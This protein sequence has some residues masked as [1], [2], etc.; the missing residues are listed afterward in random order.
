MRCILAYLPALASRCHP[1]TATAKGPNT[2]RIEFE[3]QTSLEANSSL[4]IRT[5]TPHHYYHLARFDETSH[6]GLFSGSLGRKTATVRW[7][8]TLE[9]YLLNHTQALQLHTLTL[10][11]TNPRKQAPP[12]LYIRSQGYMSSSSEILLD[13][14]EAGNLQHPATKVLA[15]TGFLDANA[16]QSTSTA[17][18][19]NLLTF[20]FKV[21]V[22]LLP[23][24]RI[25]IG[26]L[27]GAFRAQGAIRVQDA[28]FNQSCGAMSSC[29]TFF[30]SAP[31]GSPGSGLWGSEML[32]L[33][34]L[35]PLVAFAVYSIAFNGT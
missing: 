30:S 5:L 18:R 17:R 26:G 19:W 21:T 12:T 32:T 31:S 11:V 28:S 3:T 2:V 24:E 23:G 35:K 8:Q 20:R 29:H 33:H 22:P 13:S 6:P 14:G 25:T 16:F 9:L 10:N 15:V 1:C 34:V 4:I 7:N 27:K